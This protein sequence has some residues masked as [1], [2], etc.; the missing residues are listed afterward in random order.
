MALAGVVIDRFLNRSGTND[1]TV[2]CAVNF[3]GSDVGDDATVAG[4]F[5]VDV[6]MVVSSSAVQMQ[7]DIAAAVQSF[8]AGRGVTVANGDTVMS[9][10]AKT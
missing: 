1:V 6:T 4:P 3:F 2:R 9:G 10:L 8:A 7:N 5:Q